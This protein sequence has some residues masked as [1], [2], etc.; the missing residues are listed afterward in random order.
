MTRP[1]APCHTPSSGGLGL[2]GSDCEL[3]RSDQ[4]RKTHRHIPSS[5]EQRSEPRRPRLRDQTECQRIV[6]TNNDI[7]APSDSFSNTCEHSNSIGTTHAC[8]RGRPQLSAA[9]ESSKRSLTT[10]APVP[11]YPSPTPPSS[12][13]RSRDRSETPQLS[14]RLAPASIENQAM[15]ARA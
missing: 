2:D 8:G 13:K 11:M 9:P 14:R 5:N 7:A 4:A 10:A 1:A 3:K 15:C 6:N 12:I